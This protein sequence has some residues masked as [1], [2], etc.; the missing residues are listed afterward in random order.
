MKTNILILLTFASVLCMGALTKPTVS[1]LD[2]IPHWR[3]DA[4]IQGSGSANFD[5]SGSD[6]ATYI[7]MTNANMTLVNNSGNG[8]LTAQIP[9]SSTNASSGTT[10]SAGTEDNGIAFTIPSC[11]NSKCDV[12]VCVAFTHA[13]DNGAA[14]ACFAGFQIVETPNNAQTISQEGKTRINTRHSV[15]SSS[16]WSSVNLCGTFTFTTAGQKTFRL[17]YEQDITGTPGTNAVLTDM[18][19]AVGQRD[20]HWEAYP[21]LS[22]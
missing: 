8:V 20:V 18:A 5:L 22:F 15:V 3:V 2:G 9:C 13:C 19:A 7:S 10:C 16:G 14:S 4:N 21:L 11:P 6:Q 1:M 17:F 12:R